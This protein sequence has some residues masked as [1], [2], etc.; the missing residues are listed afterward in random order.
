[1]GTGQVGTGISGYGQLGTVRWGRST[2]YG[3]LGTEH[4]WV[5]GLVGTI[6]NS[7]QGGRITQLNKGK[8]ICALVP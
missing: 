6:K 5:P 8:K 2:G 7:V 3:P 1:V 4:N